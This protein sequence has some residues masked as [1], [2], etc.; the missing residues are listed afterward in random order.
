MLDV[1]DL[2]SF[3]AGPLGG[4]AQR[5]VMAAIRRRWTSLAGMGV[6]GLGYATPFLDELREEAGRTL[7]FMPA[8]QGVVA[9]PPGLLSL[10]SLVEPT[11][12]PL[13]DGVLD[14]L[15][16]VHALENSDDPAGLMNEIWRVL[17]PGG[18]L[19]IIVPNRRGPWARQD[20]TPF[21]QG[22]PYSRRQLTD[23][24]RS[25]LF[26]P[27]YWGDALHMPPSRLQFMLRSARA[28]ERLGSTLG[29]PFAG[30]HII[31]AM[32]QVYRPAIAGK[33]IRVRGL[34]EPVLVPSG[35]AAGRQDGT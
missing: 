20:T 22:R 17:A 18:Y 9:W 15:L 2:R 26:T 11:D 6:L 27:T 31:E 16:L 21:G 10:A 32:K 13:R 34:L 30:V 28:W 35:S 7:A 25:A 5:L 14:R 1:V 4:V 24:L 23:L 3:Y 12:L 19:M 33:A 8:R 29:S